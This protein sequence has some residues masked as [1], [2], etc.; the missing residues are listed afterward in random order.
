MSQRHAKP[1]RIKQLPTIS[2]QVSDFRP[3]RLQYKAT[4]GICG[5]RCA[6]GARVLWHH[7]RKLIVHSECLAAKKQADGTVRI[8][9]T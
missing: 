8:V 3:I 7:F 6:R 4:C 5:A 9:S 2:A 1:Q